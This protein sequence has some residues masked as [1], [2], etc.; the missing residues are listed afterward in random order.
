MIEKTH[1][2]GFWPALYDPFRALGT[3]VA[4][5][6]AP[7]SEASV[8][9]DDYQISLE[10]PGVDEKDIEVAVNDGILTVSG[11]K[12]AKKEASGESWYF[13]ERQFG[14]FSRSFRL[15][16]DADEDRTEASFKDGVLL[17]VVPK[18]AS[19]AGAGARK[20]KIAKR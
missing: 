16:P 1:T 11:E 15:P 13:S 14:S 3:R 4:D 5:W 7:A 19:K 10:L 17:V 12:T 18:V 6:F 9:D 2:S 20:I 8:N